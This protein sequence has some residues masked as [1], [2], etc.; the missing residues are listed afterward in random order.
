M[1]SEADDPE[2]DSDQDAP[3]APAEALR[4][5]VERTLAATAGSASEAG[6]RARNLLDDV[7]RRG[8]AAREEVSRRGEAAREEVSRRGEA[9]REQV[10]RGRQAAREQLVRRRDEATEELVRRGEEAGG[11]LADAIAD[12]REAERRDLGPIKDGLAA[13]EGRLEEL[14]QALR[15]RQPGGTGSTA[16][17]SATAPQP[18]PQPEPEESPSEADPDADSP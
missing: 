9:A 12:L 15:R 14:E 17:G 3:G 10:D 8:E 5:A 4:A 18:H 1:S 16:R 13:I 6:Q 11:R 2:T 7:T